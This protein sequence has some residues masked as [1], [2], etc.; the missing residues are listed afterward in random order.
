MRPRLASFFAREVFRKVLKAEI[1]FA[2]SH[3]FLMNKE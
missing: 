1:G 3:H 2:E